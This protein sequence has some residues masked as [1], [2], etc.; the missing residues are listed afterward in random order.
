MCAQ[1]LGP[2]FTRKFNFIFIKINCIFVPNLKNPTN[3]D[4]LPLSSLPKQLLWVRDI[5][6]APNL[7]ILALVG[8]KLAGD[9]VFPLAPDEK[10]TP[11]VLTPERVNQFMH[12]Y[13]ESLDP[14]GSSQVAGVYML[15]SLY[16]AYRS[17]GAFKD[18]TLAIMIAAQLRGKKNFNLVDTGLEVQ[19]INNSSNLSKIIYHRTSRKL[20]IQFHSQDWYLYDGVPAKVVQGLLKTRGSIGQYF[21]KNIRYSYTTTKIED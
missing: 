16:V 19:K 21:I 7:M 8:R 1:R 14:V 12:R 17:I 4:T 13:W 5:T 10:L 2:R 3:M 9:G 20:W 11:E 15:K 6:G 18:H